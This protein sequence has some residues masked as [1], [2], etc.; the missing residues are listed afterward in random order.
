MAGILC[1]WTGVGSLYT[2]PICIEDYFEHTGMLDVSQDQ[3]LQLLLFGLEVH[4][5][6][7]RYGSR[8][9]TTCHTNLHSF[10][11]ESNG[12]L[13]MYERSIEGAYLFKS[14]FSV[15]SFLVSSSSIDSSESSWS[16]FVNAMEESLS[17]CSSF[18]LGATS[19]SSSAR[20]EYQSTEGIQD[21]SVSSSISLSLS[22]SLLESSSWCSFSL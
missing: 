9:I 3:A 8:N 22:S 16:S 2:I 13:T 12:F 4:V 5:F 1:I 15:A 10:T 21:S 18:S 19:S 6:K 14:I 20:D 11:E 17:D 7:G